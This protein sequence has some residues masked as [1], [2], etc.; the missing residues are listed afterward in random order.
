MKNQLKKFSFSIVLHTLKEIEDLFAGNWNSLKVETED[1]PIRAQDDDNSAEERIKDFE[2]MQLIKYKK[3]AYLEPYK[4][5]NKSME[6]YSRWLLNFMDISNFAYFLASNC[7][8]LNIESIYNFECKINSLEET[9]VFL[10][11]WNDSNGNLPAESIIQFFKKKIVREMIEN[12]YT[13]FI[14]SMQQ[15]IDK[16]NP[17][18]KEYYTQNLDVYLDLFGVKDE[19]EK[20]V[21]RFLVYKNIKCFSYGASG[22]NTRK[23]VMLHVGITEK[24]Y[25]KIMSSNFCSIWFCKGKNDKILYNSDMLEP[26]FNIESGKECFLNSVIKKTEKSKLSLDDFGH[27]K[28]KEYILNVLQ[29]ALR[30]QKKGINILLYGKPGTGKTELSKTLIDACGAEGYNVQGIED[31]SC[32]MRY[33]EGKEDVKR[34]KYMYYMLQTYLKNNNNAIILYDEAED[35]F[36]KEE[37][38][39]QSKQKINDYLENNTTPVI[40]T[41]N[42]LWDIEQSFLRRFSYILELDT[43]GSSVLS[44]LVEKMCQEKGIKLD[45]KV[46]RLIEQEQPSIGIIKQCLNTYKLSNIKKQ[47]LLYE[48]LKNSIYAESYNTKKPKDIN[49]S[50]MHGYNQNLANTDIKLESI[51]N[52]IIKSGKNDWSLILYGVSGTGKTAYAEFLGKKLGMRVIKKKVSDLQSMWAGECEKNID[53]AFEEARQNNAILLFD[54]GDCWLRDRRLNRASW[55]TSQTNQ[56]LQNLEAATTPVIVTTNLMDSLDQAALRRFVFK[57]GFKYMTKAQVKEAFK[58]FY[59][60]DVTENEANISYA[61]PGDFAVIQKQIEYLGEKPTAG[62]IKE[63]LLG[64]IKNKKDDFKENSI[65]I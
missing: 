6:H 27:V 29:N 15:K 63:L 12:Y 52:G 39:G 47:D 5:R 46:K 19:K 51:T 50:Q 62:K 36:R 49:R 65:K 55:E 59:N 43:I 2:L 44:S 25:K 13:K 24:E 23:A 48:A 42:S 22:G 11:E 21:I 31:P 60:I 45:E 14:D 57:V 33:L 38:D 61:T 10:K 8:K 3:N 4:K 41:C 37:K 20:D 9:K 26:I 53:K 34:R 30:K 7:H 54:E 64:E 40:W 16:L 18:K 17:N 28:Q 56:F 35:F 32:P 58:T 1:R